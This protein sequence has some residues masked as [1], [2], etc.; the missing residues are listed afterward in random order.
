MQDLKRRL[1]LG[2]LPRRISVS[3]PPSPTKSF[4]PKILDSLQSGVDDPE[5]DLLA[6]DLPELEIPHGR[7]RSISDVAMQVSRLP[8]PLPGSPASHALK[9][10]L[11]PFMQ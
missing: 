4:M 10:G 5:H 11:P 6:V 8:V 9:R 2:A 1:S 3:A 7:R